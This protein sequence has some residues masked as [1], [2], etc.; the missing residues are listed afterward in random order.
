MGT[1]LALMEME[2]HCTTMGY[3]PEGTFANISGMCCIGESCGLVRCHCDNMAVV[4]VV[5]NGHS[6]DRLDKMS[7]LYIRTFQGAGRGSTL[8]R[9]R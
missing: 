3:I 4:E 8:S 1:T 6:R 5:N 2:S 9:K 7:F